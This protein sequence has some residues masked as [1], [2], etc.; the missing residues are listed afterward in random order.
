LLLIK[1]YCQDRRYGIGK[2]PEIPYGPNSAVGSHDC[3]YSGDSYTRE[4]QACVLSMKI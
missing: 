1:G 4:K 2:M 3:H